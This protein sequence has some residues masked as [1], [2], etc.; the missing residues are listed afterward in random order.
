MYKKQLVFLYNRNRKLKAYDN[1]KEI[2][3]TKA[4]QAYVHPYRIVINEM[5]A[6][7]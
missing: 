1:N 5:L 3:A 7:I 4:D 2:A 6:L